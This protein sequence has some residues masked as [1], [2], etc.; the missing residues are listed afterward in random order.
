[1]FHWHV[2]HVLHVQIVLWCLNCLSGAPYL[3]TST[4][5]TMPSLRRHG[6]FWA[7]L[8]DRTGISAI[9]IW[10]VVVML[11]LKLLLE[12]VPFSVHTPKMLTHTYVLLSYRNYRAFAFGELLRIRQVRRHEIVSAGL[13]PVVL[14]L[15]KGAGI[16]IDDNHWLSNTLPKLLFGVVDSSYHCE[17]YLSIGIYRHTSIHESTILVHY[18]LNR[19]TAPRS[20]GW[21]Y[22]QSWITLYRTVSVQA[23]GTT[24]RT[25]YPTAI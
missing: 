3:S 7:G 5:Q 2:M 23:Q 11:V 4:E 10:L 22:K 16:W 18:V 14:W 17:S 25:F 12:T 8:C 1:M 20:S 24:E 21:R 9:R 19:C 13:D 15:D 6:H